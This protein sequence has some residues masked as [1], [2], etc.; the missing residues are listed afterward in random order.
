MMLRQSRNDVML[1]INNVSLR[2]NYVFDKSNYMPS[3]EGDEVA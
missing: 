3:L 1:S 2:A